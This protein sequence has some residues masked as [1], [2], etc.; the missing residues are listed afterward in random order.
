MKIEKLVVFGGTHGNEWTGVEILKMLEVRK[1]EGESFLVEGHFSNPI[2]FEAGKRYIQQDLNRSFTKRALEGKGILAEEIIAK[3]IYDKYSKG[4]NCLIDLHTTT[5]NMGKSIVLTNPNDFNLKLVSFLQK[6]HSD[7][8][9][10]Y[11]EQSEDLAF[12]NSISPMG[13]AIETGPVANNIADPR[14]IEMNI[15]LIEDIVEFITLFNNSLL[16]GEDYGERVEVF[17]KVSYVDYIKD[18]FGNRITYLHEDIM[19]KDFVQLKKGD[20]LFK[21]Y[22]G[23]EVLF[24]KEGEYYPVFINEG[25]YYEKGIAF[26]LTKKRY[27]ECK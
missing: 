2:A 19:G 13:F 1:I 26:C 27:F 10:F 8:K 3:E 23:G 4:N 16:S 17:E 21:F 11:W 12:L 14:M 9:V 7:L 18:E 25:A 5:A 22:D 24:D 6:R 15:E 20:K